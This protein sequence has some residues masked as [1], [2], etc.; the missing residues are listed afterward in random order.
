M[1]L[2]LF[3]GL[4]FDTKN[5]PEKAALLLVGYVFDL[6]LEF[7]SLLQ[8]EYTT[9]PIQLWVRVL[10]KY[11]TNRRAKLYIVRGIGPADWFSVKIVHTGGT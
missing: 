1:L 9:V 3:V 11:T 5:G 8:F 7:C 4:F 2:A 10:S 6:I